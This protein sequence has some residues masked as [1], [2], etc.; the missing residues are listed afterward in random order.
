MKRI[1]LFTGSYPYSIAAEDTFVKPELAVLSQYFIV[2]IVP[3]EKKGT[4]DFTV[5]NIKNIYLNTNLN[6][7]KALLFKCLILSFFDI[8]LYRELFKNIKKFFNNPL[9]LKDL[10]IHN[11]KKIQIKQWLKNNLKN[12]KYS[13]NDIFYTFWFTACTSGI[14]AIKKEYKNIKVITRVHGYDLYEEERRKNYIPYRKYDVNNINFIFTVSKAGE[15]YLKRKYNINNIRTFYLGT[16]DRNILNTYNNENE[17]KLVSCSYLVPIKRV[18]QLVKILIKTSEMHKIKI[19]WHHFGNGPDY[20]KIINIINCNHSSYDI[21][22]RLFGH[23]DN[24]EIF[25]MY[26][27]NYYDY[28]IT[29]SESEG[30]V[31]VSIVEAMSCGIP[32]IATAV[33]GIPEIVINGYNGFLIEKYNEEEVIKILNEAYNLKIKK[34]QNYLELRKNARIIFKEHFSST[35][36]HEKF[37]KFLLDNLC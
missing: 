32:V 2:E 18:D 17:L 36:N 8:D 35:T 30:S 16:N 31:P 12:G 28:F 6:N 5:N 37:S 13:I 26:K 9:L 10:I 1:I 19:I 34:Y 21:D 3:L 14:L 23:L 20:N 7:N 24:N 33:G 15:N 22:L 11:L 25:N 4:Y 27:N 29:L